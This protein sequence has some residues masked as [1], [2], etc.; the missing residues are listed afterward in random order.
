MKKLLLLTLL[1]YLITPCLS[2]SQTA[3]AAKPERMRPALIVIDI[4]NAF[5]P[6]MD[7]SEV[8]KSMQ[9]INLYINLFRSKGFPIV[10]IYHHDIKY[11][12][13]PQPDTEPFEFPTSVL[14]KPDDAKVIK[15]YGDGFNKTE[16]DKVLKEKNVNTVFLCGLSAVGCVLATYI[17]AEN[18][19]YTAFLIKDALISHK[20]AYTENIENI[21]SA[22]GY[23]AINVMLDNAEK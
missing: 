8:E 2:F 4:Q 16:L 14:I 11:G 7:Q 3:D 20:A 12:Y 9:N 15:H 1:V 17:G 23:E 21:F 13:G 18:Y 6:H 22:L 5:L 10:R 19:D